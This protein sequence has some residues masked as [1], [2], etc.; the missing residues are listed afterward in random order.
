MIHRIEANQ[1]GKQAPVGLGQELTGQIALF[2]QMALQAVQFG[3]H[4]IKGLLVGLL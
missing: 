2:T 4:F 3:K 1:R